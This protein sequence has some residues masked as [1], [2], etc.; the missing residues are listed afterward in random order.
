[1]VQMI[2]DNVI[3][4]IESNRS[5]DIRTPNRKPK[6]EVNGRIAMTLSSDFVMPRINLDTPDLLISHQ[7]ISDGLSSTLTEI[8]A[9]LNDSLKLLGSDEVGD[10][11]SEVIMRSHAIR[12]KVLCYLHFIIFFMVS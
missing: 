2:N 5:G 1:M 12:H 7:S 4:H 11:I 3:R 8:A 9:S 6:Q 10:G